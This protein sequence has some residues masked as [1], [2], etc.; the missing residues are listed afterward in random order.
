MT[1]LLHIKALSIVPRLF[2]S[3]SHVQP[4]ISASPAASR[5]RISRDVITQKCAQP[6]WWARIQ[7]QEHAQV[8]SLTGLSGFSDLLSYPGREQGPSASVAAKRR[9]EF[10][11]DQGP[12]GVRLRL[13][14]CLQ[15]A[16]DSPPLC[17]AGT[18][19]VVLQL[20]HQRVL[21]DHRE[22][23]TS[24]RAQDPRSASASVRQWLSVPQTQSKD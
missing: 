16:L 7:L 5:L 1:K 21:V 20:L 10:S 8:I 23:A 9:M 3:F 2:F 14:F 22:W 11:H 13:P 12:L 4:R 24:P 18:R 15:C 6:F 17:Q 19:Q